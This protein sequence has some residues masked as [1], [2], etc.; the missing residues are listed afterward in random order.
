MTKYRKESWIDPRVERRVSDIEGFGTFAKAPICAGDVIFIFGGDLITDADVAAGKVIDHSYVNV[1]EGLYLGHRVEVG[2]S[3]DDFL[4]H[5]CQPNIWMQDE[6]TLIAM[7]DIEPGEELVIDYVMYLPSGWVAPW[8]CHC[9]T[10]Q[11]RGKVTGDDWMLPELQARYDGHFSP[12]VERKII[13]WQLQSV[14][15]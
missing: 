1:A 15:R 2:L 3:V 14:A 9:A 5:S 12:F 13:T 6:V 8:P 11:C 4:N 7:R 10:A